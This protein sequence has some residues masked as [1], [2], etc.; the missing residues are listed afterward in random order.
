MTSRHLKGGGW[1][2]KKD[3]LG[4][5]QRT[6][7]AIKGGSGRGQ[8]IGVWFKTKDLDDLIYG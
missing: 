2:E 3:S 5:I 4:D 7:E 1:C 8:K 6:F